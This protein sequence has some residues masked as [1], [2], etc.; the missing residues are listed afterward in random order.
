MLL[1]KRPHFESRQQAAD[2]DQL[3]QSVAYVRQKLAETGEAK[4]IFPKHDSQLAELLQNTCDHIID[5]ILQ[6]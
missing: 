4:I 2:E 1:G 3:N 6:I 5:L